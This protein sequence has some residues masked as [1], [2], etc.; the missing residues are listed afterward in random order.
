MKIMCL[1]EIP[2][3]LLHERLHGFC[4]TELKE[5][6]HT[7]KSLILNFNGYSFSN[8][9]HDLHSNNIEA[10]I[11][12]F[13]PL[14]HM[15]KKSIGSHIIVIECGIT[16]DQ[17]NL[18]KLKSP[19]MVHFIREHMYYDEEMHYYIENKM[20]LSTHYYKYLENL[21]LFNVF[22]QWNASHD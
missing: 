15:Q 10:K 12:E 16:P 3:L 18:L 19:K 4:A 7:L 9:I 14:Y 22:T 1:L 8:F 11:E 2:L 21:S 13:Y 20:I 5:I 17:E 6:Q